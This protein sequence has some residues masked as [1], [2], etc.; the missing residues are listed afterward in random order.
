MILFI[1]AIVL[2]A[3]LA[4][5]INASLRMS[6]LM[7]ENLGRQAETAALQALK[8]ID[9]ETFRRITEESGETE[10][11]WALRERLNEIREAAG[12][13]YLYTMRAA[14]RPGGGRE[15]VYVVD[16]LP[17]DDEAASAPGDV[18]PEV[19][20]ALLRAFETGEVQHDPVAYYE[21][22]GY[23]YS[24]YAPIVDASGSVVGIIGADLDGT[25]FRNSLNQSYIQTGIVFAV[26]LL[27]AMFAAWLA[28]RSVVRPIRRLTAQVVRVGEGDLTVD[29]TPSGRKDEIGALA[30]AA[31]GTVA[32]LR[33]LIGE[34]K[35]NILQLERSS[36]LLKSL[37]DESKRISGEVAGTIREAAEASD[38][39]LF[40][41]EE[42][43]RAMNE[44]A[45]GVNRVAEASGDAAE[46]S[47]LAG[48]KADQGGEKVLRVISQ[49]ETIAD[50]S[51]TIKR[52][53]DQLAERAGEIGKMV[54]E[55]R[56]IAGQTNI[57]AL[58]AGIEAVHAGE[59]GRGFAVVA[60]EIRRLAAQ[61]AEFSERI[62]E[63]V[64][65]IREGTA[66]AVEAIQGGMAEART[67]REAAREAGEAFGEI[68]EEVRRLS[69]QIED[70]SATAEE[71]ASGSE[72][73][74]AAVDD[75]A[76]ITR[77]LARQFAE[78][79]ASVGTQ[80]RRVEEVAHEAERL[81]RMAGSLSALVSRF[82][83]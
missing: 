22:Y 26:I 21:E 15:Y 43:A 62:A 51:E 60:G 41:F 34:L 56:A 73:V 52:V 64:G 83:V 32:G 3:S 82:R 24:A 75:V 74:T 13:V 17:R 53:V 78:V 54:G 66:Q 9:A 2:T 46:R 7:E 50:S 37:S 18:E 10:E 1:S 8:Y 63:L 48:Q 33:K 45:A 69:E 71:M 12:L 35:E 77:R 55:I 19:T 49:M 30:N 6:R 14:E 4:A 5:G 65:L 81:E 57:L 25:E 67:G 80:I 36:A 27:L 72:E 31:G 28:V 59:H 20:E 58:N 16:G 61:T 11:Y 68:R 47:G 76:S 29:V 79:S 70:V 39:Q 38:T 40:R 44:V 42:T 23:I